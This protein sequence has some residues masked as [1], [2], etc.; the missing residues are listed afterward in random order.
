[1]CK[2]FRCP[3]K[4]FFSHHFHFYATVVEEVKLK[5][6]KKKMKKN[7]TNKPGCACKSI[8]SDTCLLHVCTIS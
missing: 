2:D 8:S 6:Y 7:V 5:R 3:T 1:M 4:D